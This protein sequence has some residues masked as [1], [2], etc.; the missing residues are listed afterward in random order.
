MVGEIVIGQSSGVEQPTVPL[1][2]FRTERVYWTMSLFLE[3][4]HEPDV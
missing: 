3:I 4:K 1:G 2:M